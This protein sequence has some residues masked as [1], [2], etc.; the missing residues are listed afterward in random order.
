MIIRNSIHSPPIR[1]NQSHSISLSRRW[2]HSTCST[3]S[4]SSNSSPTPSPNE[5][6]RHRSQYNYDPFTLNPTTEHYHHNLLTPIQ[7]SKLKTR[8]RE[9]RILAR[10]F[11]HDSLYN[12]NYGYF[13]KSAVL[14]PDGIGSASASDANGRVDKKGKGKGKQKKLEQGN[15][16]TSR[17]F[18][19]N[20]IKTE[21]S[22][23]KALEQ[24]Y[25]DFE[26]S[27]KKLNPTQSPPIASS[28][29]ERKKP[30]VKVWSAEGLEEAQAKGRRSLIAT[31]K[32]RNVEEVLESEEMKPF[33]SPLTTSMGM[34]MGIGAKMDEKV[35]EDDIRSMAARQVW[36][37]PTELF[38]V[39]F[40]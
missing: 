29:K 16:P 10:D 31:Q 2:L 12:P 40:G 15:T 39:S 27:F 37:T 3:C 36:H 19:F 24:R 21:N 9:A 38:K 1:L 17:P 26:S 5:E 33:N 35:D 28:R 30:T 34:G 22:F 18:D 11:I 13:S 8:P 25:F 32:E 6:S 23:M 7:L 20:S 14:L 4:S